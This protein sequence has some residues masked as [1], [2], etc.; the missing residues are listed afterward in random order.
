MLSRAKHRPWKQP[1][2]KQEQEILRSF[3]ALPELPLGYEIARQMGRSEATI[4]RWESK[5]G[6]K[7]PARGANQ[8]TANRA[9]IL[10]QAQEVFE[11]FP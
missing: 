5:L 8:Y 6:L 10:R 9:N 4:L 2:S 3:H 1:F 11:V 7:R